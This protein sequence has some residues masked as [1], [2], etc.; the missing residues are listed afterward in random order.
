MDATN[1]QIQLDGIAYKDLMALPFKKLKKDV[2]ERAV[3]VKT[4]ILGFFRNTRDSFSNFFSSNFSMDGIEQRIEEKQAEIKINEARAVDEAVSAIEDE[5]KTVFEVY[6]E[7]D[8]IH[9]KL[10]RAQQARAIQLKATKRV[11]IGTP[12]FLKKLKNSFIANF[13]YQDLEEEMQVNEIEGSDM[14]R[15]PSIN[16]ISPPKNPYNP[17]LEKAVDAPTMEATQ[18]AEETKVDAPT[19]EATQ[20]AEETKV[21][22]PTMEATQVTEETKVDA[23]TM[24]ATQVAEKTKVDAPTMEEAQVVE[25]TKLDEYLKNNIENSTEVEIPL[26]EK[27]EVDEPTKEVKSPKATFEELLA[28]F[29]RVLAENDELKRMNSKLTGQV[30]KAEDV[31]NK[32]QE[33]NQ[34]LSDENR[35][36]K[37]ENKSL[38]EDLVLANSQKDQAVERVS[39]IENS[40]E[41]KLAKQT[42]EFNKRMDEQDQKVQA[43][44]SSMLE[45]MHSRINRVS[46]VETQER[47]K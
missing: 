28:S 4:P 24:E 27:A 15:G 42:E 11:V 29:D 33:D 47:T 39:Q 2:N 43:Q 34:R 32:T 9:K 1:A 21:D 46:S 8:S 31:V 3:K 12:V 30:S 45:A 5:F 44:L 23:P 20:V 35:N 36:V 6:K 22:A 7:H 13:T 17:E 10:R 38:K 16:P 19:M 14:E 26:V 37:L 18:V 41:E 25:E 40:Y